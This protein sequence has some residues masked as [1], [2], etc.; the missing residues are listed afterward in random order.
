MGDYYN[1]NGK[2]GVV[3]D[4]W[5]DGRHGK[6]VSIDRK[7]LKWCTSEQSYK[8]IVVGA[9]SKSNGNANTDKVMARSDSDQYPAFTWCRNKG[10]D[11]YL[12]AID[13]LELLLLNDDVHDA[14]NKTLAQKGGTKLHD[15]GESW[16]YWSSTE[17]SEFFAWRV[18]MGYGLTS[19]DSKGLS[20][21]VRAVAAF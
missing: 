11:W 18:Y 5:D 7:K 4:V 20:D 8:N 3:F 6:I 16:T 13:E 2:E 17:Y 10:A 14:V 1:E 12:P 19:N 15:K 21:F 9:D